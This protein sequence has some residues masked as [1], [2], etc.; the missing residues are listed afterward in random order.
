MP[1]AN[2]T[3]AFVDIVGF[4]ALAERCPPQHLVHMLDRSPPPP[5]S[6]QRA[7]TTPHPQKLPFVATPPSLLSFRELS[8]ETCIWEKPS[9]ISANLKHIRVDAFSPASLLPNKTTHRWHTANHSR[10][11]RD[12]SILLLH[13]SPNPSSLDNNPPFF[14]VLAVKVNANVGCLAF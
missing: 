9:R 4:T 7:I 10:E 2:V 5:P 6:A 1:A 13:S 8:P 11:S 14:G 3:V 12:F